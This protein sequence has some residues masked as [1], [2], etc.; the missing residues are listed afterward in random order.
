MQWNENGV[1]SFPDMM[2]YFEDHSPQLRFTLVNSDA[3]ILD[4]NSDVIRG[5]SLDKGAAAPAVHPTTG[6][7]YC[8]R[9]RIRLIHDPDSF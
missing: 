7:G 4:E 8:S 9:A 3:L 1:L 2:L 5:N 6:T